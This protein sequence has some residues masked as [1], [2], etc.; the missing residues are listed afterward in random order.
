[1]RPVSQAEC[2]LQSQRPHLSEPLGDVDAVAALRLPDGVEW[3]VDVPDEVDDELHRLDAV[4][5]G[6]S[7]ELDTITDTKWNLR[8]QPSCPQLLYRICGLPQ[9]AMSLSAGF[10]AFAHANPSMRYA[11]AATTSFRTSETG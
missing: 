6:R 5:A 4:V 7:P 11:F 9:C 3:L 10:C 2:R 8:R 1:M